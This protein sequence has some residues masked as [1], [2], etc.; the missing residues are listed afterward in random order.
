MLE[1]ISNIGLYTVVKLKRLYI[2]FIDDLL[3]TYAHQYLCPSSFV[4]ACRRNNKLDNKL[5]NSMYDY[6]III[7][8]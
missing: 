1:L 6:R 5:D 4:V 7:Y 3:Y 8:V 2:Y